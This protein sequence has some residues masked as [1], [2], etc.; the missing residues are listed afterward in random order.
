MGMFQ[1]RKRQ[2]QSR[3]KKV[4]KWKNEFD[5]PFDVSTKDK[6][7]KDKVNRTNQ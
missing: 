6:T 2:L 7:S 4:D 1:K 3:D 5:V